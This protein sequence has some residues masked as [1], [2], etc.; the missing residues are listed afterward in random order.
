MVES[1]EQVLSIAT[2]RSLARF[3]ARSYPLISQGCTVSSTSVLR[4]QMGSWEDA[5][6]GFDGSLDAPIE[7]IASPLG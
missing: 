2:N 3:C 4:F 7:C 1:G 6:K 5:E